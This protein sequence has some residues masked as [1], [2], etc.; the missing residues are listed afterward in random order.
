MRT[1]I[2][3]LV[4]GG[5]VLALLLTAGPALATDGQPPGRVVFGADFTLRSGESLA[6]DLVV[7]GGDATLEESSRVEGTLVVWGGDARIAGEVKGDVVAF[8]GN[9]H[10]T[11]TAVVNGDLIV[12]GG[13]ALQGEG[14]IVRGQQIVNAAGWFRPFLRW[15]AWP[16]R[17][18]AFSRP[19]NLI[20][21]L[22]WEGARTVLES[23]LVAALAGILAVLWPMGAARVGRGALEAPLASLGLGLLTLLAAGALG[24]VLILTLCLSPIGVAVLL[25]LVVAMFFGRLSLGIL[26]GERLAAALTTRTVAPFWTA[27]LGGGLLTLLLRLLDLIPCVGWAISLLV[28]CVGLGAV[29]LTRFG[30]AEAV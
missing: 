19:L 22:A 11:P 10:L 14:A 25:A 28:A 1:L 9:V 24:V 20:A 8:G 15:Y 7:F 21:S 5:A 26:L 4:F 29:V 16:F 23:L 17:V 6:G 27:A 2:R 12:L 18:D 13:T 30:T 3:L